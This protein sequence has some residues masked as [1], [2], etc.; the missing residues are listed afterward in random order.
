MRMALAMTDM[1]N[2][3]QQILARIAKYKQMIPHVDELTAGRI[4]SLD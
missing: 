1:D 3:E 4:R 2:Q